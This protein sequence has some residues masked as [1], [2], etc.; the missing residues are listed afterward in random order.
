MIGTV[1]ATYGEVDRSS[2]PDGAVSR[3]ERVDAWPAIPASKRH[4]FEQLLDIG[5][6]R[7]AGAVSFGAAVAGPTS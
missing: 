2:D 6:G 1:T 7:G 4:A 5:C 3:Q